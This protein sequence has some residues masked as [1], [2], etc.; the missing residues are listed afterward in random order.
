[1]GSP[2]S[3]CKP[4]ADYEGVWHAFAR[5]G[6]PGFAVAFNVPNHALDFT[7]EFLAGH[8]F[9]NDLY[10]H[11]G[12]EPACSFQDVQRLTGPSRSGRSIRDR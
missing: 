11:M 7:G 1:M 5:I 4:P 10:A 8:G 6:G 12:I 3:E 9:I 2:P